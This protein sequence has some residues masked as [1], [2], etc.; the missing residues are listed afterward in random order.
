MKTRNERDIKFRAFNKYTKETCDVLLICFVN[1]YVDVMPIR[2]L[3]G[4]SQESWSFK[5]IELMQFSGLKDSK[6]VDIYEGD[7]V[8]LA[9]IGNMEIEF[10]FIDLYFSGMENDIGEI[11]G[12]I[13]ENKK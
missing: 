6:G 2:N 5:D 7:I 11:K 10:P 8:Y 9:G 12:N 3:D 4:G 1:N 13:Y